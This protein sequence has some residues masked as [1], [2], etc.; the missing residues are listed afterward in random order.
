MELYEKLGSQVNPAYNKPA[1]FVTAEDVAKRFHDEIKGKTALITGC[2]LASLGQHIA[3]TIAFH[4]P[5]RII[6][7]G[8]SDVR[9]RL[10]ASN[11]QHRNPGVDIRHEVFDLADL[12]QVRNAAER[13]NATE[14]VDVIICNAGIMM[15]PLQTTADGIESQFGVNST[16]H[17]VLVNKLLPKM[18]ANGGGRVVTT[19]SGAYSYN[20]IRWDDP[21]Y[22][23]CLR[24]FKF[25]F[26]ISYLTLLI[27]IEERGI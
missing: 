15:P 8:R 1:G 19:S 12:T 7:C 21:N 3:W 13:I 24:V 23:V 20:G 4:Q 9:L 27:V 18:I 16:A 14:S 10:L 5:K 2:G 17:F 6:I 26:F 25:T 22:E 11:L